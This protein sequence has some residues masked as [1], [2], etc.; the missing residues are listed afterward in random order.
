MQS[1]ENGYLMHQ[2][3]CIKLQNRRSEDLFLK[4]ERLRWYD[5]LR[6]GNGSPPNI[7]K[8][9]SFWTLSCSFRPELGRPTEEHARGRLCGD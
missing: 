1:C 4:R 5:Y 2:A 3:F 8:G 7:F 9:M 6:R